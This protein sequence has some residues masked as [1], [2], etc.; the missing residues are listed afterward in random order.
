MRNRIEFHSPLQ[1]HSHGTLTAHARVGGR[2][3][4]ARVVKRGLEF[5]IHVDV[6]DAKTLVLR[7]II[8]VLTPCKTL[9]RLVFQHDCPELRRGVR[10]HRTDQ[11][12]P[13]RAFA[14]VQA[15]RR[16]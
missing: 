5:D 11:H 6:Y 7:Q 10:Q 12:A 3:N 16:L 15:V 9:H 14:M 1:Q 2:D 8:T 4:L 13:L